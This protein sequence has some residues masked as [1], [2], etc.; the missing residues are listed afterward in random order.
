MVNPN[1]PVTAAANGVVTLPDEDDAGKDVLSCEE[2][3]SKVEWTCQEEIVLV[4][5]MQK[6]I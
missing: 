1:V 6:N 4:K 3:K 2:G 5:H